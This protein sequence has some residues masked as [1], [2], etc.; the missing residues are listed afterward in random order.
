MNDLDSLVQASVD[1]IKFSFSDDRNSNRPGPVTK[2]A[3]E[4][5]E[6]QFKAYT[7]KPTVAPQP[8]P[9]G[10][11]E[12]PLEKVEGDLSKACVDYA[13][14]GVDEIRLVKKEE[15]VEK[16]KLVFCI[17]PH[18]IESVNS[19]LSELA[20]PT[21]SVKLKECRDRVAVS[22]DQAFKTHRIQHTD[23]LQRIEEYEEAKRKAVNEVQDLIWKGYPI[24]NPLVF[25]QEVT[26]IFTETRK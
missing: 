23:V 18:L 24:H 22:L 14:K 21:N 1:I 16:E 25:A 5:L 2:A 3:L 20:H 19:L 4:F 9:V 11:K 13:K 17:S 8:V 15:K 7:P 6:A 10:L 12:L 26:R